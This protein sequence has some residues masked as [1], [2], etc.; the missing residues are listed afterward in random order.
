MIV[1]SNLGQDKDKDR[2]KSLGATDYLVKAEVSIEEIVDRIQ[3]TLEGS[4]STAS[5]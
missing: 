2:A 3:K 4:A 5:A 1:V